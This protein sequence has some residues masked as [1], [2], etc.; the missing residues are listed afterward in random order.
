VNANFTTVLAA[1]EGAYRRD[2]RGQALLDQASYDAG[3]KGTLHLLAFLT[4]V[5]AEFLCGRAFPA[6][7][8]DAPA[9]RFIAFV[10]DLESHLLSTPAGAEVVARAKALR[11]KERMDESRGAK[12]AT[13]APLLADAVLSKTRSQQRPV[14]I[15]V[16]GPAVP[17]PAS[18]PT[19]DMSSWAGREAAGRE[20]FAR[21]AAA[22]RAKIAKL[23]AEVQDMEPG[24]PKQ[25]LLLQL[26]TLESL[27]RE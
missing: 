19:Y 11:Q 21:Q 22:R 5:S 6:L 26:A 3:S 24:Q 4:K 25:N 12:W 20:R 1:L 2:A 15:A 7:A 16:A 18:P 23:Q 13:L 17:R 27:N 9:A 14:A 10:D 8:K